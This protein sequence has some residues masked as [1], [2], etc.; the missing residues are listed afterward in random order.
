MGLFAKLVV[1]ITFIFAIACLVTSSINSYA[2]ATL[3]N[4]FLFGL[5]VVMCAWLWLLVSEENK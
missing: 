5:S 1:R 2:N 4:G 3:G